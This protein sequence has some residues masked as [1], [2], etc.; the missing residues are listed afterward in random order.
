MTA[1]PPSLRSRAALGLTAAAALG[2]FE[3]Q[4]CRSCGTV[5]Y[6]PREACHRCLS[7]VLDWR[8][9]PGGA[10][11]L[12]E[13]TLLH[14][15]DEFFRSRLPIRLGLVRLDGGP[16]AVVFLDDGVAAAPGRV[17]V[18]ARLDRSGQAVLVA[19][20]EG[21]AVTQLTQSKLLR[22][23]SCDPR[24]RTVLVTD[25]SGALGV[26]LLRA[27]LEAGAEA[28]WAGCSPAA[29]TR[30]DLGELLAGS[31]QV[32][33]VSLEVT[34]DESVQNAAA[35]IAPE[36]DI[37]INNA[38]TDAAPVPAPNASAP[39]E[40]KAAEYVPGLATARIEMDT[41]YFGLLRLARAFA[42]AMQA[43]AASSAATANVPMMAWVNLLSLYALTGVSTQS[44][45]AASKA[46]ARSFAQSLRAEM[47]PAGIRVINVFPGPE[48][49][50]AALAQ[51]IMKALREGI[52]D[53][54]P[55]EVAQDWLAQWRNNPKGLERELTPDR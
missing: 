45:F 36:V 28:V 16:A 20:A 39:L 9:Q 38:E 52:E 46:A 19:L 35:E 34:S 33:W 24:G 6:P 12:S 14:S 4:V 51:S 32:R 55:G 48:M 21:A 40:G 1:R 42:P 25:A 49:A 44:T 18:D 23:M 8:L 3:L 26:G 2:R 50:P 13:T 17:R 11:L 41:N 54:Y 43:R 10:E 29:A 5:Q 7:S 37:L 27:L 47:L 22:E 15:H 31:K 30:G 53:L